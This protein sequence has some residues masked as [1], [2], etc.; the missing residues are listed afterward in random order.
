MLTRVNFDIS[1]KI[2]K[3]IDDVRMGSP[4]SPIIGNIF[5]NHFEKNHFEELVG[6]LW[7]DLSM[8]LVLL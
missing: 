5:M 7:I 4:F 8:I 1:D 6:N 2:Y 3:Q